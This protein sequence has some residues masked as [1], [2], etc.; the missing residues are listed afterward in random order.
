MKRLGANVVR[1]HLQFAKFIDV[2]GKPNQQNLARLSKVIDLAEELGV[3]LEITGLGT[4]RLK[5][6]P[7]WYR[8]A[9]ERE[10][11]AMQAEFWHA[12][13]RESPGRV[14]LQPDE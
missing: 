8:N 6:V 12:G 11:W 13:L 3:Y 7:A 5:D 14:C 1:L 2:P 4:Y 10:H 9:N